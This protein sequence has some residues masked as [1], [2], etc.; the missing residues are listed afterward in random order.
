[1][2]CVFMYEGAESNTWEIKMPPNIDAISGFCVQIPC[3]FEIP[4]SYKKYLNNSV[5]AMWKKATIEGANVLSLELLK[6]NVIGN[7]LKKNCTT[8]FHNFPAGFNDVYF[9]RLQ[10]HAPLM[11]TFTQG[12]NIT[13]HKGWNPYFKG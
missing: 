1:M 8:V 4:D 7:I 13:V 5:K 11:Y 6:G 3:Q 12:V 10:G 9:F 2:S